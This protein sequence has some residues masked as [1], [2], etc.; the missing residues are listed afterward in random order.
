MAA[1][2]HRYPMLL[3]DRVER[4][5]PDVSITAIKAVTHQRGLL[6][7]AFPR[8]PDHARRA[9][10]RG[11]GAGRGRAR[12]RKPRPRR[13]S[14]K[15]VYFMAIEGAK[16]RAPVEPGCCCTLEVE[17]V[18]KRATVCKFAGRALV[19][20]KLAAEAQLHRD[21]RRSAAPDRPAAAARRAIR[22]IA[23]KRSLA[24]RLGGRFVHLHRAVGDQQRAVEAVELVEV[25]ERDQHERA[26]RR[27]RSRRISSEPEH[28]IRLEI[29]DRLVEQ[30]QLAAAPPAPARA[31]RARARRSTAGRPGGRRAARAR[32]GRAVR[33]SAPRRGA[34]RPSAITSRAAIGQPMSREAGRKAS[35]RAPPR[36]AESRSDRSPSIATS[37]AGVL[38]PGERA[39]QAGLAAAVGADQATS[40]PPSSVEVGRLRGGRGARAPVATSDVMTSPS[41]ACA[42]TSQR[43][44]GVPNKAVTTPIGSGR[45]SGID[46]DREIGERSAGSRRSAPP[47]AS[48][49]PGWPRGQPPREDRRDQA[50]EADRAGDRDAGADGDRRQ[51]R[52]PR[53][54]GGA[55]GG[56]ATRRRP[57]PARSGRARA[58]GAAARRRRCAAGTS[59][60]SAWPR[61]RST[62]C[63]SASRRRRRKRRARGRAPARGWSRRPA[64]SEIASPAS[65]RVAVSA[66]RPA[67]SEQQHQ[68]A[69]RPGRAARGERERLA[70]PEPIA[71]EHRAQAP[72][73]STRR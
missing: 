19:D 34:P 9:D 63:P 73:R 43:K 41:S 32:T 36:L 3:V 29:G 52:R 51:R 17:F 39:Q 7:G 67:S 58:R 66:R 68:R 23:S 30:Q 65:S 48:P 44:K 53:A 18:Q 50:D 59:A 71:A 28:P 72:R 56:R 57:R 31:A 1:L 15:L 27:R 8:P 13:I 20:G 55:A 38:D 45:P 54:P 42:T 25:V 22:K 12:G 47:A 4:L 61:L 70:E 46:A 5:E 64:A 62:S 37:P 35:K 40:C 21:D 10:R 33:R 11:A 2:P 24:I 16:F 26:R 6:P 14:G 69:Q 49:G 60:A